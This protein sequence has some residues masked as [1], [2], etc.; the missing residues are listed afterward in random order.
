MAVAL[1]LA[2]RGLGYTRPNPPVG[3]VVLQEGTV[4][5]TGYHRAAGSP[6]AEVLAL[7]EAGERSRGA[8]LCVT[9]EPCN[10][11]GRTPPCV[12]AIVKAGIRRVEIAM[13]DPNPESSRGVEALESAGVEVALGLE[14]R[15]AR[16]LLAGFASRVERKRP[17]FSV[18]MAASLDGKIA[19]GGGDSHWISS[20]VARAWVHRRR[21]EAD[22]VMVGAGTVLADD[23]RLTTRGVRGRNPDRIV[24]DS[25]LRVPVTARVWQPDGTRRIAVTVATSSSATR[26]ALAERGVDVWTLPE[27][28]EGRVDLVRLAE[29]LGG[30]G[31]TNGFVEGG[32]ILAGACIEAQLADVI[33]LVFS[34]RLLLG[35]GGPAWAEG[36]RVSSVNRAPRLRRSEISPLGPDWLC[37]L[38]PEYAQWWDPETG[39]V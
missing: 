9:L 33:W 4:V 37:T 28:A 21:R 18:K 39:H 34:R 2:R 29:R 35:G 17:R 7:Q 22:A 5:G 20:D 36:L 3:A 32:G 1:V 11:D 13:R 23:P 30:E 8:T 31:Y 6:H 12:P 19:S 14:A 26:E 10:H 16:Y 25:R 38:V 15:R 24:L 27:G